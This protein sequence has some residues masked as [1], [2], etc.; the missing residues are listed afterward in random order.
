MYLFVDS[1]RRVSANDFHDYCCV[2]RVLSK[3]NSYSIHREQK[4]I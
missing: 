1:T 3:V 4:L 2:L